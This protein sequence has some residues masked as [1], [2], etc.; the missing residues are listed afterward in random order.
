ML[1]V[2]QNHVTVANYMLTANADSQ[3]TAKITANAV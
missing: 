1:C 3:V 2:A